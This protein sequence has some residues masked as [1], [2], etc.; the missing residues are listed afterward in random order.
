MCYLEEAELE[1]KLFNQSTAKSEKREDFT[2]LLSWR[3][4]AVNVWG[5]KAWRLG[6]ICDTATGNQHYPTERKVKT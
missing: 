3:T 2:V 6:V 4:E 1:H 5:L